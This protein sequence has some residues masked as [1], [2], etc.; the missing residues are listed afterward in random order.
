MDTINIIKTEH[1]FRFED[2]GPSFQELVRSDEWQAALIVYDKY[3]RKY[4]LEDKH[5][6]ALRD[7]VVE[8]SSNKKSSGKAVNKDHLIQIAVS[9]IKNMIQNSQSETYE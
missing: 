8:F 1:G 5:L 7:Y 2:T 4:N 9:H 6:L 3:R